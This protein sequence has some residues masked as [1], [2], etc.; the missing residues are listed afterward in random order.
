MAVTKQGKCA[1]AAGPSS[2]ASLGDLDDPSREPE[3]ELVWQ[4][5]HLE[6]NSYCCK[7][8]HLAR[9]PCCHIRP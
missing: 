4:A 8:T 2:D 1:V 7:S 9:L 6:L 5:T 3:A